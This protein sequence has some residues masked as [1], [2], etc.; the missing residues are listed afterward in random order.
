M[1]QDYIVDKMDY[2]V[3]MGCIVDNFVDNLADNFVEQVDNFDMVDYYYK[4]FDYQDKDIVDLV[5]KAEIEV[6][7]LI[8][9]L[10]KKNLEMKM[11]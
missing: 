3:D 8:G 6:D 1:M 5:E 9:L 10:I 7:C 2:I 4:Y 11:V